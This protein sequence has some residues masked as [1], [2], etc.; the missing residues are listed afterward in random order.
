MR[1]QEWI[2]NFL[3]AR[4]LSS[5]TGKALYSYKMKEHEFAS[6]AEL[7]KA[8]LYQTTKWDACFVLYAVEW[9]RRKYSGG[10]WSWSPILDSINQGTKVPVQVRNDIVEKGILFWKRNI[11]QSESGREFLGTVI[12]ESGIPLNVLQDNHYLADIISETYME[13]GEI[14]TIEYEYFDLVKSIAIK[15]RLP[16]TLKQAGFIQVIL[17]TVQKLVVLNNRFDLRKEKS[18]VS[19]LDNQYAGWRE[20]FPIRIDDN[21]VA[22]KFLDDLLSGFSKIEKPVV[23]AVQRYFELEQKHEKWQ[24]GHYLSITSG[25]HSYTSL[26]ISVDEYNQLARKVEI[27]VEIKEAEQRIGFA[28]KARRNDEDGFQIDGLDRYRLKEDYNHFSLVFSDSKSGERLVLKLPQNTIYSDE[29][30]IFHQVD[31]R[32]RLKTTGSAT[33]SNHTHLIIVSEQCRVTC[34]EFKQ[35]GQLPD[36]KNIIE[37]NSDCQIQDNDNFY[38]IRFSNND[39]NY[40]YEFYPSDYT[41]SIPFNTTK[42]EIVFSGIPKVYRLSE[43]VNQFSRTRITSG[44]EYFDGKSWKRL[45]DNDDLVGTLKI[46]M[47]GKEQETVFC[48]TISVLPKGVKFGI[49]KRE[50]TIANA[51]DLLLKV[52]SSIPSECINDGSN[53]RLLFHD[54]SNT[55]IP[56]SFKLTIQRDKYLD[57]V[58]LTIPYPVSELYFY[59]ASGR[60]IDNRQSYFLHKLHGIRLAIPNSSTFARNQLQLRLVDLSMNDTVQISRPIKKDLS[61]TQSHISLISFQNQISALFSLTENIDAKVEISCQ[62][63]TIEIRK[64][65][66]KPKIIETNTVRIKAIGDEAYDVRAFR[67]DLPFTKDAVY[68]LKKINNGNYEL[69]QENG[70]WIIYPGTNSSEPFRP[71]VFKVGNPVTE[72]MLAINEVHQVSVLSRELRLKALNDLLDKIC[73]NYEHPDWK[74]LDELYIETKHLPLATNDIWIA[75]IHNELALTALVFMMRQEVI[76]QL[77]DEFSIIWH[78][79][80][81]EKWIL[82]FNQYKKYVM[83]RYPAQADLLIEYSLGKIENMLE[84]AAVRWILEGNSQPISYD[85]L[86][87]LIHKELN[88]EE[89][90]PGVRGRHQQERWPDLLHDKLVPLFT[91]LPQEFRH[92]LPQSIPHHQQS[93]IYLPFI[94]AI[95]SNANQFQFPELTPIERLRVIEVIEFD[96]N[97]FKVLYDFIKGYSWSQFTLNK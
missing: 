73:L 46:R 27:F 31:S 24:L 91:D 72:N 85:L 81:I 36:S 18:P 38:K 50:V 39:V 30:L 61:G 83:D 75:I 13:L 84:L 80:S 25:F 7:L 82:S 76:K 53:K 62:Q 32:W 89:G 97:W 9:W 68:D 57:G 88:G 10:Y 44:L 63:K 28:F 20:D 70:V 3:L 60:M 23:Y 19:F 21:D 35:I 52:A 6:L 34:N 33:L 93:V 78:R 42:N 64:F 40:R 2:N 79:I 5:V 55:R 90:S 95:A 96:E 59:D 92:L 17:E 4:K 12:V 26:G 22:K 29:P 74:R 1:P 86:K 48:R 11:F 77:A 66:S 15:R 41:E 49:S 58:E 43:E 94:L 51:S 69:P 16:E 47:I 54:D 56:E 65:G 71:V 14:S 67:L 87:T 37:I 8:N 45:A